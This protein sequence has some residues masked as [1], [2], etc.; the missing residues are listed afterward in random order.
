MSA[1]ERGGR[2]VSTSALAAAVMMASTFAIYSTSKAVVLNISQKPAIRTL[3][4]SIG[5]SILCSAVVRSSIHEAAL[6]RS[7][8]PR[9]TSGLQQIEGAALTPTE[10]SLGG[11]GQGR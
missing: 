3:G 5:I 2:V 8:H 7:P 10:Q 11:P 9:S 4:R 1:H 6:S